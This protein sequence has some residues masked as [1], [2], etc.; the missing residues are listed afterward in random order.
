MPDPDSFDVVAKFVATEKERRRLKEEL[1]KV[2]RLL[3]E[4]KER[5]LGVFERTGMQSVNINGMVV[6]LSHQIIAKLK[7]EREYATGI[8]RAWAP[9]LVKQSFNMNQVAALFREQF[10]EGDMT[11]ED[12]LEELPEPIRAC[13]DVND[14]F[15]VR[16]KLA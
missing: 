1:A 14:W 11:L 13:F 6:Y 3:K 4:L 8:L 9:E 16:A 7:V 10:R 5:V 15:D 12:F 2:D